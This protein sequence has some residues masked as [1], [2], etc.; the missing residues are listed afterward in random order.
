[1]TN[2]LPSALD[3][4]ALIWGSSTGMGSVYRIGRLEP[5]QTKQVSMRARENTQRL[6]DW[7]SGLLDQTNGA[8]GAEEGDSADGLMR[9][10]LFHGQVAAQEQ[11]PDVALPRLD[12]SWR[13]R[14]ADQV[15]MFARIPP[16]HAQ[17]ASAEQA[18]G[19]LSSLL[20]LEAARGAGERQALSGTIVQDTFFRFFIPVQP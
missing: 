11:S 14:L 10:L 15:I 12:Q 18:D 16:T 5:N 19:R 17:D 4:V 6:S 8:S 3:E 1:M 13:T 9:R 20:R 7:A 2:R